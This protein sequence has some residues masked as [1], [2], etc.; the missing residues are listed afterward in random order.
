[1]HVA[2][3][4]EEVGASGYF[5]LLS[6][7]LRSLYRLPRKDA[8]YLVG[9]YEVG[10]I[11][12]AAPAVAR[13]GWL[14]LSDGSGWVQRQL[15]PKFSGSVLIREGGEWQGHW[16]VLEQGVLSWYGDSHPQQIFNSMAT[17]RDDTASR[18][19]LQPVP[20][21]TEKEFGK[22]CKQLGHAQDRKGLKNA[23]QDMQRSADYRQ[24]EYDYERFSH[25][26]RHMNRWR[27]DRDGIR[28]DDFRDWIPSQFMD[29]PPVARLD[30]G[31][32]M[33]EAP[34]PKA[35]T[36]SEGA[37]YQWQDDQG[38][39]INYVSRHNIAAIW[40]AFFSRYQRYRC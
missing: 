16:C 40:V 8:A 9:D 5:E 3:R 12:S 20:T 7:S 14:K 32:L 22:L 11:I 33:G 21:I 31:V 39:W 35:M 38:R 23:M 18:P 25:Q 4:Q 24:Y 27:P 28:W 2:C 6:S 19:G 29:V 13:P 1:M 36:S 10:Q 26:H 34:L 37:V 30:I 17:I 15:P